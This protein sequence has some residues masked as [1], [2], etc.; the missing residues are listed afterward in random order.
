M[1]NNRVIKINSRNV[2]CTFNKNIWTLSL[3]QKGGP[4]ITGTNF[5]NMKREFKE[6]LKLCEI[7]K[8]LNTNK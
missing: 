7:V 5:N 3:I 2:F 8:R 6:A 1:E 4:I